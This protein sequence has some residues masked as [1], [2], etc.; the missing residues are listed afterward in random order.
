MDFGESMI[1]VVTHP[2][3]DVACARSWVWFSGRDH[4]KWKGNI[5][6]MVAMTWDGLCWVLTDSA[7]HA[8]AK[9]PFVS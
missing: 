2:I 1:C 3:V 7:R 4:T 8:L 6:D 5:T 9:V